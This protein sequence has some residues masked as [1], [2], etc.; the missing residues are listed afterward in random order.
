MANA[1]LSQSYSGD[2]LH[3]CIS[4]VNHEPTHIRD[5][6]LHYFA[7]I[8]IQRRTTYFQDKALW[9]PDREAARARVLRKRHDAPS[10]RPDSH[11]E[12]EQPSISSDGARQFGEHA[13]TAPIPQVKAAVQSSGQAPLDKEVEAA[14]GKKICSTAM[15]LDAELKRI[16]IIRASLSEGVSNRSPVAKLTNSMKIWRESKE[17]QDNIGK[18]TQW[19]RD[20]GFPAGQRLQD[21]HTRIQGLA[22]LIERH[23][24]GDTW[25]KEQL[26]DHMSTHGSRYVLERDLKAY[27]MEFKYEP[28]QKASKQES[29][30]SEQ[31]A[32]SSGYDPL[33]SRGT[34]NPTT[35]I[36][37][38]RY[39][40]KPFTQQEDRR[41]KGYFPHQKVSVED[42]LKRSDHPDFKS[43]LTPRQGMVRYIHIP[44][45]NMEVSDSLSLNRLLMLRMWL[46]NIFDSGSRLVTDPSHIAIQAS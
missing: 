36:A 31:Q 17:Y 24:P 13:R 35:R 21:V 43:I 5:H 39:V 29:S 11:S 41:Y 19:R 32:S 18:V 23:M 16:E 4:T 26:E 34:D 40:L 6:I 37:D 2:E 7:C 30:L 3:T 27:I 14:V 10:N 12:Q 20:R 38:Q 28:I 25:I 45:N 42:L 46:T 33:A 44:C 22:E 15:E 9:G 1:W 8:D